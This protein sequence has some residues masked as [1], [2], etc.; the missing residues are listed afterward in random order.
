MIQFSDARFL[1]RVDREA[2]TLAQVGHQV[3]LLAVRERRSAALEERDGY[4][5]R[6][7]RVRSRGLPGWRVF[8]PLKAVEIFVRMVW[9]G[10]RC[11]AEVYDARGLEA[12]AASWTAARLR[13]AGLIYSCDELGLERQALAHK[14]S[15]I[16]GLYGAS[17]RFFTKRAKAVVVTDRYHGR[18]LEERYPW[19][20]PIVVRN[21][22]ET[23]KRVPKKAKVAELER[24]KLKLLLYQGILARGRGLEEVVRSLEQLEDCAVLF[25]GSGPLAGELKLLAENLRV[26]D[27]V[28]LREP[29]PFDQLVHYTAAADA[30]IALTQDVSRSDYLAV[31]KKFYEYLMNGVPVIASDFPE[32]REMVKAYQVGVLVDDPSDPHSIARAARALFA[33]KEAYQQMRRRARKIALDRLNWEVEK[34]GLLVALDR[35]L[36][37]MRR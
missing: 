29:M 27:R 36:N 3:W 25:I 8:A 12:L 4:V 22:C 6:R 26:A 31:P 34:E 14:P 24:R 13:R 35:T 18:A 7:V 30:G 23:V 37:G 2:R 5:V 16:I 20:R 9:H 33:D 19:V 32:M 17:E 10:W 21:A 1:T 15:W 28:V 11:G